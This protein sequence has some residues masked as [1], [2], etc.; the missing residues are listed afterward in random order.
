[1]IV[2]KSKAWV[3]KVLLILLDAVL[4]IGALYLSL[5]LRYECL[6]NLEFSN[7]ARWAGYFVI[8][9]LASMLLG[10]MYDVLWR[11]AGINEI[12]RLS[13]CSVIACAI[14]FALDMLFVW[15]VSRA[16]LLLH[17]ILSVG[18]IGLTRL[19]WRLI[20]SRHNTDKAMHSDRKP[21]RL[22]IVGAGIAG[23]YV[24]NMCRSDPGL[25]VPVL[26]VDDD[27]L[28]VRKRIQGIRVRGSIDDIPKLAAR[29]DIQDI[30]IAIPSLKGD[31]LNKIVDLCHETTCRV[32]ILSRIQSSD[33]ACR[34]E[35]MFVRELNISDFLSRNEVHLDEAGISEYLTGK[36]VLVTGGG[37]SI[38]SEIA[39]QVMR[40]HP[41]LLIVFDIYENCA[42]ELECEL[43]RK[44]GDDCPVAVRI[45]SVR[46]P[47]RLKEIFDEF[48]PNVVFHAAAHKHVPLMEDSPAE[49]IKNNVFG[50]LNVLRAAD[51]ANVERFVLLSTDK[52]VNPTNVM[53]ASKRITEMVIQDFAKRT[54]MRCMAVRFGNVLGSHGSVIPLFDAQIKAGG[55]VTVTHPDI[56]R[57]FMTIPE[58]AQLVLQ[59]GCLA[60]TGSIYVLD[61][62]KPVKI[63]DLAKKLIRFY[64]Y[65][66][67]VTMD[68]VYT[69]LRPGE[70]LFEELLT[71][72]E[73]GKMR[74][75][76]HE[77]IMIAPAIAQD[78]EQFRMQLETLRVAA[79]HN[80]S[81]VVDVVRTIVPGFHAPDGKKAEDA[82]A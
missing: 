54:R 17:C 75:T 59:A 74:K 31:A 44:H 64:G 18:L 13:V 42:Y 38:G 4:L 32:R 19:L 21:P 24:L 63:V 53:G 68:I 69:G 43:K 34:A 27:A 6:W 29:E 26:F 48:H 16:V 9:Y 5:A 2:L 65:E 25:G 14:C 40:F 70:K 56:I 36:T 51:A 46:E 71:D 39:R 47:A 8:V 22:M 67:G 66:P 7:T 49:A 62:G 72:A 41:G 15:N 28:K 76:A 20:V 30:I 1:M 52:A 80:D 82:T 55:P 73:R 12:T 37:G 81:R 78:A 60:E 58:A 50:T 33:Q 77:K 61:M 45:G 57:F 79:E 35:N 10:G 11:Y 3:G 23:S